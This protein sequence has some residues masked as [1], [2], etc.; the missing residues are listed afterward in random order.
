MKALMN[1]LSQGSSVQQTLGGVYA[2]LVPGQ[3]SDLGPAPWRPEPAVRTQ[4]GWELEEQ[5]VSG[6]GAL[7]GGLAELGVAEGARRLQVSRK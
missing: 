3:E 5:E 2:V 6:A 4:A 7:E 1:A